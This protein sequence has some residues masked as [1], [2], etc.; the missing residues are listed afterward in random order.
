[1][2]DRLSG[3]TINFGTPDNMVTKA[4]CEIAC[5]AQPGATACEWDEAFGGA[6]LGTCKY[7]TDSQVYDCQ[8]VWFDDEETDDVCYE[9]YDGNT[10]WCMVFASAS[11]SNEDNLEDIPASAKDDFVGCFQDNTNK[12]R[13]LP[14]RVPGTKS[15]AECKSECSQYEFFGLQWHS[16]CFC[17]NSP[18]SQGFSANCKN[19]CPNTPDIND[20]AVN[21]EGDGGNANCVFRTGFKTPHSL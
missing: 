17:G 12:A 18:G 8:S 21:F 20:N 1:M 7:F 13:D 14:H 15:Y 6:S 4:D 3:H 19:N 16:V 10:E 5:R 9:H 2:G 11:A